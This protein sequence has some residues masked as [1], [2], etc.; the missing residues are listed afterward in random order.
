MYKNTKNSG[1]P[2]ISQIINLLEM[3]KIYRTA[4]KYKS[5]RYYKSF[6]T[7]DHLITMLYAVLSGCNSLRE[8]TGIMLACEGRI[9]HLGIK[10]FPKRSTL[11]DANRKRSSIV[12][13]DI[14]YEHLKKYKQFISDSKVKSKFKKD[15][16]IVDSTTISLFC[17]ILKGTGRHPINGKKKGGIKMHTM[18]S[19][20]ED[21]PTLVIFSSAATHDSVFLKNLQLKPGSIVVFD[22]GYNDYLQYLQW[23]LEGVYF[24]TRIKDNAAYKCLKEYDIPDEV[25]AGVIK[26]EKIE[27]KKDDKSIILRRIA[28]W[29]DKNDRVFEFIT[30]NYELPADIIADIY[31]QRWQIELLFKRLKQNFQLKYFLGDNQNAIEIQIWVSL[32]AQLLLMVIRRLAKRQWAFSN[33]MSII[34]FHL[35]TYINLLEFLNNPD[36]GWEIL[37]T[38]VEQPQLFNTS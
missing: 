36:A 11:S 35:M 13:R 25:S 14:Y 30:N 15:L 6:I 12:F 7:K 22:R 33:L 28:Y 1:N 3:S 10:K 2:V 23:N 19:A 38:K 37:K 8:I 21:V 34:R 26:D 32:L 16:L 5:D 29:D 17:N 20:S 31:K 24:V 18:I 27:L 4:E 9:N